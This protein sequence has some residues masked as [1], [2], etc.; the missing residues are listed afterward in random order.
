MAVT[1]ILALTIVFLSCQ[2]I[3]SI[4][5]VM[6][7]W[8]I[9]PKET[10]VM[11]T[12][13]LC[14]Y[15]FLKRQVGFLQRTFGIPKAAGVAIIYLTVFALLG[16]AGTQMEHLL[17]Q[18]AAT[19]SGKIQGHHLTAADIQSSV[20]AFIRPYLP[21][22]YLAKFTE[23]ATAPMNF[24][25]GHISAI[26][27]EMTGWIQAILATGSDVFFVLL[28]AFLLTIAESLPHAILPYVPEGGRAARVVKAIDE[29]MD[30]LSHYVS[31]Q[32]GIGA[33]YGVAF[34]SLFSIFFPG[35]FAIAL[36]GGTIEAIVPM[37]GSFLTLTFMALPV[38]VI[39]WGQAGFFWGCSGAALVLGIWIAVFLIQ[40]HPVYLLVMGRALNVPPFLQLFAMW[41]FAAA[42]TMLGTVLVLPLLV[43]GW[44]ILIYFWPQLKPPEDKQHPEHLV[45]LHALNHRMLD[46]Y[47]GSL[48]H[49]Y[50]R[51]IPT[52]FDNRNHR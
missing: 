31:A 23:L 41:L 3:L 15:A 25:A 40:W 22:A 2:S 30:G 11:L 35:G 48:A 43:I 32:I 18:E 52:L 50:L 47:K 45:W 28:F 26:T 5:Q 13:T 19:I 21:D 24:V 4:D 38:A 33:F 37:A 39:E 34:G 29:T 12:A 1:V 16:M 27:S 51:N 6:T 7:L 44:H 20:P 8:G 14:V 9:P 10:I 42:F 49:Q 46:W 17:S 36:V